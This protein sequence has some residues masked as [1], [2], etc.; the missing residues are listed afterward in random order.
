MENEKEENQSVVDSLNKG[1]R[2]FWLIWNIVESIILAAAGVLAVIVGLQDGDASKEL[3]AVVF[4]CVVGAYIILDGTLRFLIGLFKFRYD[5]GTSM[6]LP[7]FEIAIGIVVIIF[8]DTF[9]EIAIYFL[10]TLL[11]CVGALM[12]FYAIFALVKSAAK[13][14]V[15]ILTIIF[16]AVLLGL[17]V[18]MIILYQNKTNEFFAAITIGIGIILVGVGIVQLIIVLSQNHKIVKANKPKKEKGNKKEKIDT[19]DAKEAV[20]EEV[21]KDEEKNYVIELKTD[22]EPKDEKKKSKDSAKDDEPIELDVLDEE[23]KDKK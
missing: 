2:T 19:K 15:P 18:T 4:S 12:L 8:H 17:G 13:L 9:L 22:E 16:A 7:A 1:Q 14:Y 5:G 23:S 10:S 20:V 3:V 6:I 21:K 11:I